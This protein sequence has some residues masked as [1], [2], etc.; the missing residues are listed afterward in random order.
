M[1]I[2]ILIYI[3]NFNCLIFN[4]INFLTLLN[5][6]YYFLIINFAHMNKQIKKRQVKP[7]RESPTGVRM[8]KDLKIKLRK[9]AKQHGLTLHGFVLLTLNQAV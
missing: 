6:W 8:P 9:K 5:L 7:K 2:F 1:L 4:K 3:F